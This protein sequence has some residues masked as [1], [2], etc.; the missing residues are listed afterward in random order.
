LRSI[1]T[2]NAAPKTTQ[3]P[4]NSKRRPSLDTLLSTSKSLQICRCTICWQQS[5][6]NRLACFCQ[7]L[8]RL[9]QQNYQ[10][11]CKREL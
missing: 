4:T 5:K 11:F 10:F 8:C 3:A 9:S 1:T 7:L 6:G 2:K